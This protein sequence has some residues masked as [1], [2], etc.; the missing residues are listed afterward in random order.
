M[1]LVSFRPIASQDLPALKQLL[2]EAIY[3]PADKEKLP[4]DVLETPELKHYFDHFGEK[5][6]DFGLIAEQDGKTI[7]AAWNR[8]LY[9]P[10]RG[11]GNLDA[12]T[13]ELAIALFPE[14]RNQGIGSQLL[15]TMIRHWLAA[16]IKK[17]SLSVHPQNRAISL[18]QKNGFA[19]IQ[20]NQN[21][22][23]MEWTGFISADN[24][25]ALLH[26]A[27]NPERAAAMTRFFKT[28]KGQYAEGD[29]FLGLPNP[30]VR[31][32]VKQFRKTNFQ[33]FATLLQNPYHEIRLCGVLGMVEQYTKGDAETRNKLYRLYLDHRSQINN[34]DLVDL[35]A[36]GIVGEHL[37]SHDRSILKTLA[38]SSNLWEQRIAMI[39]TLTLI[40]HHDFSATINLAEYFMNHSHDL[41]HKAVGWMLREVG[42]R[43]KTILTD[44]LTRHKQNMPRTTLRYAIEHYT[45]EERSH[46]LKS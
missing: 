1:F 44:F 27:A 25:S 40:R 36:P 29:R 16:G 42:K 4:F 46:F 8:I 30:V 20:K 24:M 28:G 45:P 37:L 10:I 2:Y 31:N 3:Q 17:I 41:I 26:S 9:K 22:F 5:A 15:Q 23:L 33:E 13:P 6:G 39:S 38:R 11:Y 7:G 19:I 34:W 12:R 35:S 18:Y 21:D 32:F 43:D 14:F